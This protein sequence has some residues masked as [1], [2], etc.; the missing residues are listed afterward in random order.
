MPKKLLARVLVWGPALVCCAA[1][2]PTAPAGCIRDAPKTDLAA[3]TVVTRHATEEDGSVAMPAS[4]RYRGECLVQT[5]HNRCVV[6]VFDYRV[7]PGEAVT[8]Q[9]EEVDWGSYLPWEEVR[10][11]FCFFSV[12]IVFFV[13]ALSYPRLEE[14]LRRRGGIQSGGCLYIHIFEVSYHNTFLGYGGDERVRYFLFSGVIRQQHIILVSRGFLWIRR[15]CP[16]MDGQQKTLLLRL[17]LC[18]RQARHAT[19]A[20]R[21]LRFTRRGQRTEKP[22]VHQKYLCVTKYL[23]AFSSGVFVQTLCCCVQRHF[24]YHY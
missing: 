15:V 23:H 4:M 7:A 17:V 21:V 10:G 9:E 5:D 3:S 18:L 1:R 16:D 22:Y 19:K 12:L 13:C 24:L 2:H 20:S 11:V 8:W 6:S 14:T